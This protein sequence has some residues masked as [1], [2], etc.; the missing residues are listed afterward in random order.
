MQKQLEQ[1]ERELKIRNYSY[2]TIK[3]YLYGLE[4]YFSFK[5]DDLENPD[6]DNIKNFSSFVKRKAHRRS[7]GTFSWRWKAHHKDHSKSF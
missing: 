2:K 3:S 6:A 4:D 7:Q 1:T 5:R